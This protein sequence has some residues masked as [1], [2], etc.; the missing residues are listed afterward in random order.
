MPGSHKV[1]FNLHLS[2]DDFAAYYKGYAKNVQVRAVDG[3]E[4][5]FPADVLRKFVTT[6]G[7]HGTFE[8]EFDANNKLV[9]LRRIDRR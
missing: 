1:R 9:D 8:L 4:V 2:P 7:I 5:R 3:R 6:Y